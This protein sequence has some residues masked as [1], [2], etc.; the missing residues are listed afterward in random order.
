[1]GLQQVTFAEEVWHKG[2][3]VQR[4]LI[5]AAVGEMISKW[6]V[7]AIQPALHNTRDHAS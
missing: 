6:Q 5:L 1:V 2:I 7:Q 3:A 4:V